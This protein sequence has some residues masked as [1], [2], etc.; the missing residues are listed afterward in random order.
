MQK[1][2]ERFLRYAAICTTSSYETGTHPST[3]TQYEFAAMLAK[4]LGDIGLTDITLEETGYVM[5]TLPENTGRQLPVIGFIAHMDTSPDMTAEKVS[6]RV[7][8]N[9]D[10]GDI[11]VNRDLNVV[12]SP[13]EFP[14]LREYK[15]GGIV[16][17]DGTTL[18]G[19]DD[20]AGI[21]EIVTAMEH[22][23]NHP[24]IEHGRIRICFTPD[25]E[26]GEGA[27]RFD[28]KRFGADFAYTMDGDELGSLEYE[29]FNA[30]SA[31]IVINGRNIHPGSAKNKMVNSILIAMEL[32][33][34]L[35]C[36]EKP[37]HTEGYEGFY[38]LNDIKGS[39]EQ[40]T[41][42]YILRDHDRSK[43]EQKKL[44]IVKTAAFLNEKYGAGTVVT[45]IKDQYYNMKEKVTPVYHIVELAVRAMESVG[46]KP[47]IKPVRGGTDGSRLSW[48]GL[49]T[50]NIFTGGGNFHGKYEFLSVESMKKAAEVIVKIAELAAV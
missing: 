5:A 19:A 41:M 42:K 50:P 35:P 27:D 30:A 26:I 20:K 11:V 32:E 25:E 18:L 46:V 7:V 43:F 47:V 6:P 4:E 29:N 2:L 21:A 37:A 49:P 44:R 45:E 8:R 23:I 22:L 48:M 17:T 39:V 3:G 10:G 9:Y 15:G 36:S 13:D 24:E 16:V 33:A 31:N 40:T 28:V 34:L 1:A 38:H 14:S 12:L